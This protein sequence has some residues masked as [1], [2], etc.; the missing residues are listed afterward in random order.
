MRSGRVPMTASGWRLLLRACG[1]AFERQRPHVIDLTWHPAGIPMW[2][3]LNRG[4]KRPA[5]L[6]GAEMTTR[7]LSRFGRIRGGVHHADPLPQGLVGPTA[8][9]T[10]DSLTDQRDITDCGH[11]AGD[12]G[13]RFRQ[14]SLM[15]N[16]SGLI[17]DENRATA[18]REPVSSRRSVRADR[19]RWDVRHPQLYRQCPEKF[20]Q[21][22]AGIDMR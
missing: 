3:K 8:P 1:R 7:S 15:R 17:D 2:L 18:S 6:A 11:R 16:K 14:T 5:A 19:F 10:S 13:N 4:R 21:G 20:R 12:C 9:G 22:S